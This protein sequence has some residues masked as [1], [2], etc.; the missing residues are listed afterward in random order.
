M[1]YIKINRSNRRK[2]K[3]NKYRPITFRMTKFSKN[4]VLEAYN[5]VIVQYGAE[6]QVETISKI[7]IW[8]Y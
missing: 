5:Q 7:Y 6:N 2:Q 1:K 4:K 3:V 8:P